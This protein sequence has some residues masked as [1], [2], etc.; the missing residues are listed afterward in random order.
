VGR[1]SR[2]PL[3]AGAVN[4]DSP[5]LRLGV[6]GLIVISLFA[7]LFSRLW[8]LQ[9]LASD[10]FKEQARANSIREVLEPA[11]RGRILDRRGRVLVDNRVSV[12][13]TVDRQKLPKV[14]KEE[15]SIEGRDH[16][17]EYPLRGDY[18]LVKAH[19]ADRMGNL[20]YR[21]TAR[22]FGPVMATAAGTTVVQVTGVVEAGAL[23]PEVVV[24]PGIYVDRVV[25]VPSP[26]NGSEP[27]TVPGAEA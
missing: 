25:H 2:A 6:L 22:N 18:A 21:K 17:L 26:A 8:Y 9:I 11:P 4:P 5:R 10:Q 7:T 20:V 19:T 16:V 15:R 27:A 1:A 23:D 14:G 3:E 13:V 12:V 24:T